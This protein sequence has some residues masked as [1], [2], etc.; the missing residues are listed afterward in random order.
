MAVQCAT[1]IGMTAGDLVGDA[2]VAGCGLSFVHLPVSGAAL[3]RAHVRRESMS[4]VDLAGHVLQDPLIGLNV[5]AVADDSGEVLS[6]RS[7][8]FVPGPSM[9]EDPATGS[10]AVGLGVALVATGVAAPDG[11]T[12]YEIEQGVELGRPSYLSGRVEAS[13]GVATRCWVAGQVVPIGGGRIAIP[14]A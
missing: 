12:R 9:P 5:F 2:V 3:T 1:S 4:A 6:V 11:L 7:R 10:A 13:A 14:P 8:V